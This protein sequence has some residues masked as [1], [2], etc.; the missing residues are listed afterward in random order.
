MITKNN[1]A[2]N[3]PTDGGSPDDFERQID[4]ADIEI[5]K[6]TGAPNERR[7]RPD[8]ISRGVTAITILGWLGAAVSIVF[9]ELARPAGENILL[10]LLDVTVVSSWD[11]SKLIWAYSAIMLSLVASVFG[12]IFNAVRLRRK[13][14]RYNR[15]L[16]VL[17]AVS[18]ILIILFLVS[19]SRYL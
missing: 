11:S 8:M 17:C 12:L 19:Y 16:I 1:D 10:R 13:A 9:L 3:I 5:D 2:K 18:V 4:F 7:K 14:D 15:L 6:A